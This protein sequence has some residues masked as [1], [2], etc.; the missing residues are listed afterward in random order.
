MIAALA[1][2]KTQKALDVLVEASHSNDPEISKLA[3][4]A[5]ANGQPRKL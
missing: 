1:R 2:F 5:L 4:A 3:K